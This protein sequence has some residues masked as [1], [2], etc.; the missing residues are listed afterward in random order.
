MRSRTRTARSK[1]KLFWSWMNYVSTCGC[2]STVRKRRVK[3]L[4]WL[5]G[6]L[7]PK[8]NFS[9]R[10]QMDNT[11]SR[12]AT[13]VSIVPSLKFIPHVNRQA[14]CCSETFFLEFLE[15]IRFT[16]RHLQSFLGAFIE[17]VQN[18]E[19]SKASVVK[20]VSCFATVKARMQ[21]KQS[22]VHFKPS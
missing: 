15:R 19:K 18:I 4:F 22:E 1:T 16:L 2:I 9:Y 8:T 12:L 17:Q 3:R 14:N 11:I 10:N 21:E 6:Y 7:V 13:D 5:C 20:V